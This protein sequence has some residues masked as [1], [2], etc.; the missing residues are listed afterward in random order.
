M[1]MVGVEV[2]VQACWSIQHQRCRELSVKFVADERSPMHFGAT[3]FADIML[4]LQNNELA[5]ESD[6]LD[7]FSSRCETGLGDI[8]KE[9]GK[10]VKVSMINSNGWATLTI[11]SRGGGG[12]KQEAH[13]RTNEVRGGLAGIPGRQDPSFPRK[14]R[15][16]RLCATETA[17]SV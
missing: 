16:R 11:L 7:S 3:S 4:S 12:G 17:G 14:N 6:E 1:Q 10:A 13:S 5:F 15:L 8:A 9:K 2:H